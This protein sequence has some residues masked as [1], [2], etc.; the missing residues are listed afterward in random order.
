MARFTKRPVEVDA[1]RVA[2]VIELERTT[3]SRMDTVL[4]D[5]FEAG[6]LR[7]APKIA[8]YSMLFDAQLSMASAYELELV[9][10]TLEGEVRAG[11]DAMLVCGIEGEF[12]PCAWRIFAQTYDPANQQQF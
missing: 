8:R 11:P 10:R 12:Y 7:V 9:V 5:A 1:W 6:V 4:R 2:D 3:R